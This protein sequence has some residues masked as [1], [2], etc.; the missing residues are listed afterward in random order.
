M[1]NII[2]NTVGSSADSNKCRSGNIVG[3]HSNPSMVR[4]GLGTDGGGGGYLIV[5]EH[6]VGTIGS[7]IESGVYSNDKKKSYRKIKRITMPPPVSMVKG[8]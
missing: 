1:V 6:Q 3:M 7:N 2:S 5:R 8:A 4:C